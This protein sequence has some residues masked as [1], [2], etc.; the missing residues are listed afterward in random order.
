MSALS[1]RPFV[2]LSRYGRPAR[3]PVACLLR[4]I[5]D[6]LGAR[7]GSLREEQGTGDGCGGSL[8]CGL[9][10]RFTA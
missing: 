10:Y 1:P 8:V 6:L 5:D 9:L 3:R 2:C 4:I 7:L